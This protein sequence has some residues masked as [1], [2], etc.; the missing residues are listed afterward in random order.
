M[1]RLSLP[2]DPLLRRF[3]GVY[4]LYSAALASLAWVGVGVDFFRAV[5]IGCG[6]VG[7][8]IFG[9]HSALQGAWPLPG[10]GS[11]D[12]PPSAL[13]GRLTFSYLLRLTLTGMVLFLGITEYGVDPIGLL[14]G[15]SAMPLTAVTVS[16]LPIGPDQKTKR[17]N[18]SRE[19]AGQKKSEKKPEK[20]KTAR[21]RKIDAGKKTGKKKGKEKT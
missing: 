21:K 20:D 2:Q 17:A 9:L 8:N 13:Q 18:G 14:A 16:L 4:L 12:G 1:A 6:I 11:T 5:L 10:Q 15:L 19:T 7:F 3:L